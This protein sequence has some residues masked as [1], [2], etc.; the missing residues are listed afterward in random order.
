MATTAPE[1][2]S[3][4]YIVDSQGK[5]HRIPFVYLNLF[6]ARL[7]YLKSEATY[8]SRI[9]LNACSQEKREA[10]LLLLSCDPHCTS[11]TPML[12]RPSAG[13]I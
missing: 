6:I 12:V 13:L 7:K 2:R 11:S 3:F 4:S 5:P 1:H 10:L 8:S 9:D